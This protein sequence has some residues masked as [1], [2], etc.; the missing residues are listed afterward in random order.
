MHI[1]P[2]RA[3]DEGGQVPEA[4]ESYLQLYVARAHLRNVREGWKGY[5]PVVQTS[6][7][8]AAPGGAREIPYIVGSDDFQSL[9]KK[10]ELFFRD[11][12]ATPPIPYLGGSVNLIAGVIAVVKNDYAKELI[13]LLG[14]ISSVVGGQALTTALGVIEPLKSGVEGL[15][16]LGDKQLKVGVITDLSSNKRKPTLLSGYYAVVD[17]PESPDLLSSLCVKNDKL[18]RDGSEI[19]EDYLL[20]RL[21]VLDALGREEWRKFLSLEKLATKVREAAAEERS[22]QTPFRAF[23]VGV[24][25]SDGLIASDKIRIIKGLEA[26]ADE[27]AGKKRTPSRRLGGSLKLAPSPDAAREIAKKTNLG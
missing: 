22:Y 8:L 17:L 16:R 13:G 3:E 1:G 5:F 10:D 7:R 6:V 23:K 21:D 26:E 9:G 12:S 24:Q 11:V 15:L 4:A 2:D 25:M 18:M 27:I 19:K 20:L 14:S